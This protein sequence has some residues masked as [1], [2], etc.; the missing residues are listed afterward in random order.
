MKRMPK[1]DIIVIGSSA[2]GVQACCAV[3]K[4]LP[5]DL[6]ASLFIVQ[7]TGEASI[8]A[9]VL[10]RCDSLRVV[11]ASN[12]EPIVRSYV[13]VAPPNQ[14]LLIRDNHMQLSKGP[15]ENRHRPSVDALFRSAARAGR[16]RVIAVVLTGAL[17]DGAAGALAVK[18]RGGLVIVQHPDDAA[19]PDMPRNA[20][21]AVRVDYCVPLVE[22]APLLTKLVGQNTP[23]TQRNP[24]KRKR[25]PQSNGAA[26]FTCPECNGPLYQTEDG[27]PGEVKCLIGHRFSPEGLSEA[28]KEA[29]ERTILTALRMINERIAIHQNLARRNRSPQSFKLSPRFQESAEAA[30]RDAALLEEILERL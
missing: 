14:H 30:A 2:G 12:G 5:S 29:L 3:L 25:T 1:R 13:Y 4:A 6:A 9:Q 15:R 26:P 19:V 28:H 22:I 27:P 20:M 11:A 8:L 7:H 17:D 16:S 21:R 10:S 24:P 18:T 23:M